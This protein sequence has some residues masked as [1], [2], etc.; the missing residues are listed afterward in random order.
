MKA[1]HFLIFII[2]LF[3]GLAIAGDVEEADAAL[4]KK[5]YKTALIK[6]KSAALKGDAY[7]Q[8]QVGNIYATNQ[9]D[10][11]AV[12]WYKLSAAQGY[13]DGQTSLAFKYQSGTGVLQNYAEAARLFKLAASQGNTFAQKNLGI[14]YWQGNGVPHDL[15]RAHMWMNL[16]A[17]QGDF[18]TTES[19]ASFRDKISNRLS[20]KQIETAQKMAKD[21]LEKKY[22]NCH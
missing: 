9:N 8:L 7:A 15:V 6:Y 1:R 19:A 3:F 5:D 18:L 2:T 14:M 16:S 17:A 4:D 13:A 10:V 22:K 11:E 12:K 21:C 20:P